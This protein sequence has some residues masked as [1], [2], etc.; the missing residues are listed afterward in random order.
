MKHDE[1]WLESLYDKNGRHMAEA[2]FEHMNRWHVTENELPEYGQLVD[3]IW[4]G[5]RR[6][7]YQLSNYED[8]DLFF[9]PDGIGLNAIWVT[10]WKPVDL[11]K[12]E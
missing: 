2:H 9:G 7:D 11:P 5:S 4:S 12:I 10:H 1:E 6:T 8:D 3:I